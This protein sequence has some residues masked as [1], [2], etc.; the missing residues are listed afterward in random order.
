MA[1]VKHF[2]VGWYPIEGTLGG[3]RLDIPSRQEM[4]SRRDLCCC[5]W[6]LSSEF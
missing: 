2:F 4:S 5:P 3:W 1:P 6:V